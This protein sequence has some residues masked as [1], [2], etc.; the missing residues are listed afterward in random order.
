MARTPFRR[1]VGITLWWSPVWVPLALSMQ[2]ATRGLEPARRERARLR[3]EAPVVE[4]RYA[5]SQAKVEG[6]EAEAA[7]WQDPIFVE[8]VRRARVAA[9][10][11]ATG[12]GAHARENSQAGD[13]GPPTSAS[14]RPLGPAGSSLGSAG[15][16]TAGD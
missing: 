10:R 9:E 7:A 3:A 12:G 1:A 13:F 5:A 14:G 11:G 15:N 6:L 4:A 2:L 8:R 16:G